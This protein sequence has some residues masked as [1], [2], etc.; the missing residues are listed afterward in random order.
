MAYHEYRRA[1]QVV[2]TRERDADRGDMF[3]VIIRRDPVYNTPVFITRSGRSRCLYEQ[4]TVARESLEL[5]W[6]PSGFSSTSDSYTAVLEIS[7]TGVNTENEE[8][9]YYLNVNTETNVNAWSI[10]ANGVPVMQNTVPSRAKQI[11]PTNILIVLTGGQ[12][13]PSG[14]VFQLTGVCY[15]DIVSPKEYAF[16][17][18]ITWHSMP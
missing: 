4:G 17:S 11:T 5:R 10:M 13:S 15:E 16:T 6:K 3:D 1:H 2:S 8:F 9:A 14:L 12:G 18:N 7:N